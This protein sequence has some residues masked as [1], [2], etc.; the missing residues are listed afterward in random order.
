MVAAA[1]LVA[2]AVIALSVA[3]NV[4]LQLN[5]TGGPMG[6]HGSESVGLAGCFHNMAHLR[7][8]TA[9]QFG[10]QFGT[11]SLWLTRHAQTSHAFFGLMAYAH[12]GLAGLCGGIGYALWRRLRWARTADLVLV[13][14]SAALATTHAV[15]LLASGF[16]YAALGIEILAITPLVAGPIL[17]LLGSPRTAALFDPSAAPGPRAAAKRRWWTLSAQWLGAALV[18]AFA[19]GLVRLLFFGPMV[20]V[21]WGVARVT[22]PHLGL[23]PR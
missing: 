18:V 7:V 4:A 3:G 20:E 22:D 9:A 14:A 17:M 13:G 5:Y 10:A 23:W 2:G 12:L 19:L 6:S 21:V 1:H 16:G 8:W 11:Y 15:V